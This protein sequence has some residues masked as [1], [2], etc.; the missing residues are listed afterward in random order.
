MRS[1]KS[2]QIWNEK[3]AAQVR[4]QNVKKCASEKSD[5]NGK[6]AKVPERDDGVALS[7]MALPACH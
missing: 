6:V 5:V 7:F 2:D 4:R 1:S 3:K